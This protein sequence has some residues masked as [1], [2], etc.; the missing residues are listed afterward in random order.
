MSDSLSSP[1]IRRYREPRTRWLPAHQKRAGL[2]VWAAVKSWQA[3]NAVKR[4]KRSQP[5]DPAPLAEFATA[6]SA[7]VRAWSPILPPGTLLTVP[8]Q[9]AS[10]PGPYA[11]L[12]FGYRVAEVLTQT[13]PKR[14]HGPHSSLRQAPFLCSLP[15]SLPTM[16]LVLDNLCTSGRTMRHSIEAIRACGVMAFGFAVSGW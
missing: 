16:V 11:A 3:R 8:P 5:L 15:E 10:A 6:V 14:W 4:W 1:M 2:G 9:G 13:E 7:L 12:A